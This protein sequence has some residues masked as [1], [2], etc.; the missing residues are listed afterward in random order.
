M[1]NVQSN[2][3]GIFIYDLTNLDQQSNI[4]TAS[5]VDGANAVIGTIDSQFNY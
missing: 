4:I 3:D 2:A 5:I 1:G